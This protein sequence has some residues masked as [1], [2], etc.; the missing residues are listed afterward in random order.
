MSEWPTTG[1]TP[2]E[3]P[4]LDETVP[5]EER[6]TRISSDEGDYLPQTPPDK[7]PRAAQWA[8][9]P[10]DERSH[11]T[12]DQRIAQEEPDPNSAYGAPDNESGLDGADPVGG[13]DPDAVPADQ[14]F[15]GEREF[16]PSNEPTDRP[17]EAA[18]IHVEQDTPPQ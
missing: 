12:I 9:T 18:A 4:G 7:Q 8:A 17:A 11:E 2:R 16:D 1:N 14:D 10:E 15:L 6:D 3:I 13:D 5:P